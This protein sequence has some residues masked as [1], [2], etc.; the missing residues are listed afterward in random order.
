MIMDDEISD[1]TFGVLPLKEIAKR[2]SQLIRHFQSRWKKEYLTSLHEYHK[3]SGTSKQQVQVGDVVIIHNDIQRTN[4]KLAVVKKSITG[5]DG[6]SR[7][8]EIRTAGGG[9]T[10]L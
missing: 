1:P 4:Q 2:Q 5:L 10:A 3:A 8:A 6:V 7:A 9:Q